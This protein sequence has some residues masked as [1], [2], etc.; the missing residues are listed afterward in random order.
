M[1]FSIFSTFYLAVGLGPDEE[2]ANGTY[3]VCHIVLLLCII[4]TLERGKCMLPSDEDA[5]SLSLWRGSDDEEMTSSV[6]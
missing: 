1:G 5:L 4:Y 2:E 6:L 3:E